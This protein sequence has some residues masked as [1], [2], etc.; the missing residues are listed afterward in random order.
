MVN[1][2]NWLAMSYTEWDDANQISGWTEMSGGEKKIK[3]SLK[4]IWC[5]KILSLHL[6]II[7]H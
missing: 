6:N 3:K 7:K 5:I 4:I 1:P 2:Q